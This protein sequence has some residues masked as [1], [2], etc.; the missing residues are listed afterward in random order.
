M[1]QCT[2]K[3]PLVQLPNLILD[4]TFGTRALENHLQEGLWIV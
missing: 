4:Q 1:N 2:Q 3:H